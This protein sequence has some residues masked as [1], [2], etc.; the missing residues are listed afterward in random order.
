[1]LI[2][3][4]SWPAA[5]DWR[6]ARFN[7]CSDPERQRHVPVLGELSDKRERVLEG[8]KGKQLWL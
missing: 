2:G 3:I 8:R 1:V 7:D 4:L 5:R 6:S